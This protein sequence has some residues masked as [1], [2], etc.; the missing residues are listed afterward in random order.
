MRTCRPRVK[1]LYLA[2]CGADQS[3]R[4][5]S[6]SR[7][8]AYAW[9]RQNG[10]RKAPCRC[11]SGKPAGTCCLGEEGWHKRPEVISLRT[12]G[13]TGAHSGCY[14]RDTRACCSKISGEHLLSEAVLKVLAEN[15]VEI[16]GLPWQEGEKKVFG[17]GALTSNILC[18]AH[19]SALS[20][21]DTAGSRFFSAIQSCGTT[22]DGSSLN[23][24][25]SGHDIERW[26]LRTV[27]ALAVSKNFG[28]DGAQL[29]AGIINRL[30]LSEFLE[31]PAAWKRPLGIYYMQGVGY[32]FWQKPTIELQPLLVR[33]SGDIVGMSIDIQ[34]MQIG[35]LAAE[36]D[37]VGTGF[38]R[39][40]YRP[41]SLIFKMGNLTNAIQLSWEDTLP[42]MDITLTWTGDHKSA[43]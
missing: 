40:I 27:A 34:G 36:H 18:R 41:R 31:N 23:F 1:P 30:Q 12:T 20:P 4:A 7:A 33:G 38:D 11:G 22:V 8:R 32:R 9:A 2:L 3:A 26:L 29:D 17:F 24:L 6:T 5:G 14:L 37:I 21:L 16:S 10:R 43:S 15:R 13:E 25:V 19:N 35:V 42:H 39:A 28:I